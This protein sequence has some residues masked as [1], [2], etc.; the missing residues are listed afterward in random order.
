MEDKY[1][2]VQTS[3]LNRPTILSLVKAKCQKRYSITQLGS[4][5]ISQ[6]NVFNPRIQM[7]ADFKHKFDSLINFINC[8]KTGEPQ[9]KID[10]INKNADNEF[11]L[12]LEVQF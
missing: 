2:T 8:L 1:V 11:D 10:L 12:Q 6:N 4:I 9:C 5:Y 3:D 7:D